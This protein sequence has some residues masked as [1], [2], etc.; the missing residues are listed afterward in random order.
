MSAGVA[1]F[2][3]SKVTLCA[4]AAKENVTPSPELIVSEFGVYARPAVAATVFPG[5]VG[6]C[7]CAMP[8]Y[9]PV[10]PPLHAANA[11]ARE[12]LMI[13]VMRDIRIQP[14]FAL[15][16]DATCDTRK[17]GRIAAEVLNKGSMIL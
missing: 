1:A 8:P 14:E 11:T 2:G 3:A 9:G 15:R 5:G 16:V 12:A 13:R 4:T 17:L 7:Y 6:G 10:P